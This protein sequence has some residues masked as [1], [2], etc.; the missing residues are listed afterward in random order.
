MQILEQRPL[1]F[2]CA[3]ACHPVSACCAAAAE[4]WSTHLQVLRMPLFQLP[5]LITQLVNAQVAINRLSEF[6][7][8]EQKPP[9]ELL[10]P[11]AKG[12]VREDTSL[13]SSSGL[14]CASQCSRYLVPPHLRASQ[15]CSASHW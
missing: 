8:A 7:A 14:C 12:T 3:P 10:E 11:A 2:L 5:Q 9:E 15:L 4:A 13:A 6:L 1:L